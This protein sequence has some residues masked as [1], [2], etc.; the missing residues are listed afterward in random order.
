MFLAFEEGRGGKDPSED[1][2]DGE[3]W[4][5][6]NYVVPLAKKL[7]ECGVFGVSS[8]ECFNYAQEN[9]KEVSDACTLACAITYLVNE[10]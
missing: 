3:L 4:F 6:D 5:F 2:Y 10:R 9:R 1:W 7:E 8:D